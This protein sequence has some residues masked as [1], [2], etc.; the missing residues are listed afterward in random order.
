LPGVLRPRALRRALD[1]L[2]DEA[3]LARFLT[4]QRER[5]TQAWA[6]PTG[7]QEWMRAHSDLIDAVVRR[8]FALANER[9]ATDHP[10]PPPARRPSP[11]WRRAATD[12]AIWP[13]TRIWTSRFC[14]RATMTR[15][16]AA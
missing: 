13:R 10:D 7:G 12:G 16:R 8:L 5:L 6:P 15:T 3:A 2:R 11:S 4:E 9:A 1:D 14:P